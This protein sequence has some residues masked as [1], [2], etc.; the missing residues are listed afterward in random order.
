MWGAPSQLTVAKPRRRRPR[1]VTA[2]REIESPPPRDAAPRRSSQ[3]A[4]LTWNLNGRRLI[5]GQVEAMGNRAPALSPAGADSLVG[6][7][8]PLSRRGWIHILLTSTID[9][10]P[11]ETGP[12]AVDGLN[13]VTSRALHDST[14]PH[15]RELHANLGGHCTEAAAF[16]TEIGRERLITI[17]VA[18]SGGTNFMGHGGNGVIVVWFWE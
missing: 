3:G 14:T 16:A 18:A 10:G 6:S 12:P 9:D 2:I 11:P 1:A 15:L 7:S 5:E 8:P 4:L 13:N 17:S